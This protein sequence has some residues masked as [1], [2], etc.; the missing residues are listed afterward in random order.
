MREAFRKAAHRTSILVGSAAAFIAAFILVLV[1]A[2]SGPLF[3]F[4]DTWQLIINTGTTVLTFLIVFLIQNSQNR[5]SEAIQLKLD[6]LLRAVASAR[7]GLADVE[8]LSDAELEALKKEF[9]R[10]AESAKATD[11]AKAT[12]QTEPP[13]NPEGPQNPT[14]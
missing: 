12:D 4:S 6:E 13:L 7:T 1:W 2:A 3:H 14:S 10:L 11:H 9:E 8:N 5:G